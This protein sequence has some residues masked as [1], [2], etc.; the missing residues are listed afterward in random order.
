MYREQI[1]LDAHNSPLEGAMRLKL[2]PLDFSFRTRYGDILFSELFLDSQNQTM[3]YQRVSTVELIERSQ[4]T[5]KETHVSMFSLSVPSLSTM[6]VRWSVA[7]G[8]REEARRPSLLTIP[9]WTST[10]P[11][12]EDACIYIIIYIN[13][14]RLKFTLLTDTTDPVLFGSVYWPYN[15]NC[16]VEQLAMDSPHKFFNDDDLFLCL[17][18]ILVEKVV[19]ITNGRGILYNYS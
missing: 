11:R 13:I 19:N 3:D 4:K 16:T 7:G 2:A 8:T 17:P 12:E 18:T 14:Y 1:T 9:C 6:R 10:T 5:K 15:G